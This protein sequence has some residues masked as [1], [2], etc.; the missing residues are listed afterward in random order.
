[1]KKKVMT[2]HQ[3]MKLNASL[4]YQIY[5]IYFSFPISFNKTFNTIL[6]RRGDSGFLCHVLN[7]R[8]KVFSFVLLIEM[9]AEDFW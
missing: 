1:M 6:N 9:S 3:K 4:H 2:K 8:G 5:A 7:F